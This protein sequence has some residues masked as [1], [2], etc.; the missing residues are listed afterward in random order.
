[1]SLHPVQMPLGKRRDEL[2]QCKVGDY[3]ATERYDEK[4]DQFAV[5]SPDGGPTRWTFTRVAL[6]G[7]NDE[8]KHAWQRVS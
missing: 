3:M 5:D 8:P 7:D 2:A 6:V 4:E 1:M